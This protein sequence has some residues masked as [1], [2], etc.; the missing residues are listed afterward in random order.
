M[1]EVRIRVAGKEDVGALAS[2]MTEL[3][4][5][6]SVEDMGRRFEGISSDP[7]YETFIAGSGDEVVG[8]IGIRL[9][10]TY[11]ADAS[12]ARIMALVVSSEHRGRGSGRALMCAAEEW[13][14]RRGA[15]AIVLTTHKRRAGAH[16]FYRSMGY[17]ATGYRFYKA[18]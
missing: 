16:Q 11:E 18:L 6:S 10:R 5:P 14:R 1:G 7:S 2:L 13:A 4:Y 8:M 9:E 17:E 15:E 12:C 3:G